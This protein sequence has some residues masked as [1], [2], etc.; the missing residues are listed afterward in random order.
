MGNYVGEFLGELSFSVSS[1]CLA[2]RCWCEV[3]ISALGRLFGVFTALRESS[4]CSETLA[5]RSPQLPPSTIIFCTW[6]IIF[7]SRYRHRHVSPDD[8]SAVDSR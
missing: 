4:E 7:A 2:W 6:M 8:F 3:R 1:C 5:T